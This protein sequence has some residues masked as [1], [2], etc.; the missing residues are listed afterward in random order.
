MI[1]DSSFGNSSALAGP[2][3]KIPDTLGKTVGNNLFHS[4]AE[5][6]IQTGESATFAGV[7]SIN[8][9]LGR[10]TGN[11]ASTIDGLIRSEIA[12]ANLYLLNPNGFL[13]GE[14]ANVD[15]DGAFTI[16]SRDRINLGN[17]GVFL[18]RQP[19][20]SL[21][22]ASPP[23]A[24]GF[25]GSN[26]AGNIS[27]DGSRLVTGGA[28]HVA[29]G[30]VTLDN[31]RLVSESITGNSGDII[32]ESDGVTIRQG[33]LRTES[34]AGNAGG[35]IISSKKPIL[36]EN[37]DAAPDSGEGLDRG[38]FIDSIRDRDVAF[39]EVTGL[40]SLAKGGGK[41]G[42][43]TIAGPS[44]TLKSAGLYSM[45]SKDDAGNL[46][47]SGNISIRTGAAILENARVQLGSA[48]APNPT[49][50][51]SLLAQNGVS[52]AKQSYLSSES[53]LDISGGVAIVEGSLVE[54][55]FSKVNVG[56][57]MKLSAN[58]VWNTETL[59]I[60]SP[61]LEVYESTIQFET[62][63]A[64]RLSRDLKL[65]NNSEITGN[66]L[67]PSKLSLIGLNALIHGRAQL[68][69]GLGIDMELEGHFALSGESRVQVGIDRLQ[70]PDLAVNFPEGQQLGYLNLKAR[71]ATIAEG[72]WESNFK[73][74]TPY[75]GT[76]NLE[77][78]KGFDIESNG[79]VYLTD[80][81]GN[82]ESKITL[83]AQNL[84]I[85]AAGLR[86]DEMDI[87]VS[88]LLKIGEPNGNASGGIYG[89]PKDP[90]L[91]D[92]MAGDV[93]MFGTGG[94]VLQKDGVNEVYRGVIKL[95]V[96]RD[97]I[98]D[99]NSI[100]TRGYYKHDYN[101]IAVGSIDISAANMRLKNN[102]KIE[103]PSG[104]VP[105]G[106]KVG[107]L[108]VDVGNILQINNSTISASVEG[109]ASD[110]ADV[111]LTATSLELNGAKL[112]HTG[113]FSE[114]YNQGARYLRDVEE[115][116]FLSGRGT[117][118][119]SAENFLVARTGTR[120]EIH[121][122]ALE[123]GG[124]V[125]S[126]DGISLDSITDW[127]K[128][129][130]DTLLGVSFKGGQELV[131]ANSRLG[132]HTISSGAH[133]NFE[134][135][136]PMVVFRN[137]QVTML[138]EVEGGTG[139]LSLMGEDSVTIQ[140]SELTSIGMNTIDP[141]V[142]GNDILIEG[143]SLLV[144]SSVINTT[145][146]GRGDL[147]TTKI[148]ATKSM[149]LTDSWI[150]G[151]GSQLAQLQKTSIVLDDTFGDAVKITDGVIDSS[152]GLAKGENVFYSLA[153]LELRGGDHLAFG[154]LGADQK[155]VLT[156]VTGDESSVLD[157]T[158]GLG[159]NK[160]DLILMNPSGFVVG[161]NAQ[162][163]NVGALTLF[164]GNSVEFEGGASVGLQTSADALPGKA[165][166]RFVDGENGPINLIGTTLGQS[167]LS[168]VGGDVSFRSGASAM[169][170]DGTLL[171]LDVG[172]LNLSGGS[173]I[174]SS[175]PEG[176]LG[177]AIHIEADTLNLN[178]GSIR[179]AASGGQGGP[180]MIT[181]GSFVAKGGVIESLSFPG[182]T[183][184]GRAGTVLVSMT[185]SILG[186][187]G[188][189]VDAASYG[190]GG[191]SPISLSA[192]TV[193]L[194]GP[195]FRRP[196]G[197]RMVAYQGATSSITIE[198][199]AVFA[200]MGRLINEARNDAGL[201]VGENY[202]DISIS[203]N[204]LS[205]GHEIDGGLP[206]TDATS[207]SF[208][209]HSKNT[210]RTGD[211]RVVAEN[212]LN[213]GGISI[214][215]EGLLLAGK[216][217]VESGPVGRGGDILFKGQNVIGQATP[218]PV[219]W[220]TSHY[221][222]NLTFEAADQLTLGLSHFIYVNAAPSGAHALTFK[223]K[224]I[225]LGYAEQFNQNRWGT[226]FLLVHDD[227]KN[228]NAPNLVMRAE[229]TIQ[230]HPG[231]HTND[232]FDTVGPNKGLPGGHGVSAVDIQARDIVFNA[233]KLSLHSNFEHRIV[234]TDSLQLTK[235]SQIEITD[236]DTVAQPVVRSASLEADSLTMDSSTYLRSRSA[237][238]Y[239]AAD[240]QINSDSLQLDGARIFSES[241]ANGSAGD[242]SLTGGALTLVNGA[243]VQSLMLGA[244]DAGDISLEAD[245]IHLTG[246]SRVQS[247][248]ALSSTGFNP[249]K[250]LPGAHGNAG[251]VAIR[252]KNIRLDGGSSLSSM[253]LDIGRSGNVSV[254]GGEVLFDERAY[255]SS[256]TDATQ[257][258]GRY[259]IFDSTF[260][261]DAD[262]NGSISLVGD[263][264][265][266]AGGA[267]LKSTTRMPH[268]Q[269]GDI[270]L[271]G[272]KVTLTDGSSVLSNTEPSEMITAWRQYL[273]L[274]GP[275][276]F[277]NAGE[278]SIEAGSVNITRKSRLASD[279]FTDG[280]AGRITIKSNEVS[281]TESGRVYAGSLNKGDGGA[282]EIDAGQMRLAKRGAIVADVRDTGDGGTVHIRSGEMTV[283]AG[284]VYGSTSGQGQGSRVEIESDNLRLANGGRIESAAFGLGQAGELNITAGQVSIEG[285]GEWFDPKD[286]DA[287][288]SGQI[289]RSGLA[290][291]TVADG[292]AGTIN[293]STPN[294]DLDAGLIGSA[295]TGNGEAGSI[296]LNMTGQMVLQND[297]Q[298]SVRS[299]MADG[300]DIT[301]NTSGHVLVDNSELS[302]SA[303]QDGGS[304]RLY[305]NGHFF[306]RDGRITAEAGQDGGNIFVEAPETLVLNRAWLSANAIYGHGGYILITAD[307]FLPSV[308]TSITASS[309]FG[310]EG[311]VEIRTPDTDVGSGL[312]ILPETLVSRNVNLAER[313]ALRLSGDVSSFFVN[314]E[315]GIPVWSSQ[316]YLPSLLDNEYE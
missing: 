289:A 98:I 118:S 173:V 293:L 280:D 111:S 274:T 52:L 154:D 63:A 169:T 67:R 213:L 80:Y 110:R 128:A 309:E 54:A 144:K 62:E 182:E 86:A 186:T 87:D 285:E 291:G 267:Y 183:V 51:I 158:V 233:S 155:R 7:D 13:F 150:G 133:Q 174:G 191:L 64:I 16:S 113:Y 59:N 82:P 241:L 181:G 21:L 179:T 122:G 34:T 306:F 275:T 72:D 135:E 115:P 141:A 123:L 162:F 105:E 140:D 85:N 102:A 60:T 149:S 228:Y 187:E 66:A 143:G 70:N 281:I 142:N 298:V 134:F 148:N 197:V 200:P 127:E 231:F 312:V 93:E 245:L 244:G 196:S 6:N 50:E 307:G 250:H 184:N 31:A 271:S 76:M 235:G 237:T 216:G 208:Y 315:G 180:V 252:G 25:L 40:L 286:V 243:R 287:E 145:V 27:F 104:L 83:K 198:G 278:V 265:T 103:L 246:G 218:D 253:A 251:V 313:C 262:Q 171:H 296:N 77:V 227:I 314:G 8:N 9:I 35:V 139:R 29:G 212:D 94:I 239:A 175:S 194:D 92:I 259:G 42:G 189:F 32:V 39:G 236:S 277:G 4:F 120:I 61:V 160:G 112:E 126:L 108:K 36:I 240:W 56:G 114:V 95:D 125:I 261:P 106:V 71:S 188:A 26:P 43:I 130:A 273:K 159:A 269:A 84:S 268:R 137:N 300:G 10:V 46:G 151:V 195:D 74:F 48:L 305:G 207:L 153:K 211:I 5:F 44:V 272:E 55:Q 65:V 177:G 57:G 96:A 129:D 136:A 292:N 299:S 242:V 89:G 90:R 161:P 290:T 256:T 73:L 131:I 163:E 249:D 203:G 20:N 79:E 276:N 176:E 97:L 210:G 302:A 310:V 116:V 294:L 264:V 238:R 2:N 18:A 206:K 185:E 282:I 295:S 279:S 156:R 193:V 69:A 260:Q 304:V 205:L 109:P 166:I 190:D 91:I 283:D 219:L 303:K 192:P 220:F 172:S 170:I 217:F 204:D 202:G 270:L 152:L 14:N 78:K 22:T 15:V 229:E 297:G 288:P 3:F 45:T 201:V 214:V 11:G 215:Q 107:G 17:D 230:F 19:N 28:V 221:T 167:N 146:R 263:N 165:P 258:A 119:L 234:A 209:T 225:S 24:F 257:W 311:T 254:I 23:Q 316:S 81:A 223:G 75:G 255:V 100:S 164:T 117:M 222:G 88:G 266:L 1:V 58:S 168:I 41:T 68:N 53:G 224:N 232:D 124:N 121:N 301:I 247:G 47:A 99:G 12:G 138:D 178:V 132:S 30:I 38:E 49:G 308:E 248:V 37:P 226:S 33:Q 147:G 284:S 157:G 101:N 199:D